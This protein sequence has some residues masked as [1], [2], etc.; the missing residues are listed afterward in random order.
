METTSEN[1]ATFIVGRPMV[2]VPEDVKSSTFAALTYPTEETG[3]DR[4]WAQKRPDGS[5]SEEVARQVIGV[6]M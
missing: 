1:I 5:P 2:G 3:K 6:A 4:S